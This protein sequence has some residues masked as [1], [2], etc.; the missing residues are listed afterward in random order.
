MIEDIKAI[1]KSRG[2]R[3]FRRRR[4][5]LHRPRRPLPV[6]GARIRRK[7]ARSP[8]SS[9]HRRRNSGDR[10]RRTHGWDRRERRNRERLPRTGRAIAPI[11]PTPVPLLW[12]STLPHD[13]RRPSRSKLGTDLTQPPHRLRSPPWTVAPER[14]L[15]TVRLCCDRTIDPQLR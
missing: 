7:A 11:Q 10:R 6:D 5:L 9:S 15:L 1:E 12:S 8:R 3:C 13:G 2:D 14:K 4:L